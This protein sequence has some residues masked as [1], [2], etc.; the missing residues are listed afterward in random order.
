MY[1]TGQKKARLFL[2]PSRRTVPMARDTTAFLN[3]L[4]ARK[5]G[6]CTMRTRLQEKDAR[7]HAARGCKNLPG[8]PMAHPTLVFRYRSIQTLKNHLANEPTKN[9]ID[10]FFIRFYT[11][12]N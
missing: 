10:F 9:F 2:W 11:N 6:S 1:P 7:M 8:M 4:M 5:T 12:S 3:R